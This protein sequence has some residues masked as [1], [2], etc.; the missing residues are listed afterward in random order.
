VKT[1][2]SGPGETIL[3]THLRVGKVRG[4]SNWSYSTGSLAL[5]RSSNKD[6]GKRGGCQYLGKNI[7]VIDE[8]LCALI[9]SLV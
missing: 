4:L 2:G 1:V 5:A 8:S 6:L 3:E 9:P 7:G